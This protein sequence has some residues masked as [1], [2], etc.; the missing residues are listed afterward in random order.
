MTD[1]SFFRYKKTLNNSLTNIR[2]IQFLKLFWWAHKSWRDEFKFSYKQFTNII[3]EFV[4]IKPNIILNNEHNKSN[5]I[6]NPILI[7]TF[8]DYKYN[9]NIISMYKVTILKLLNLD[10]KIHDKTAI[11]TIVKTISITKFNNITIHLYL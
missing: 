5:T 10:N 11:L 2:T 1:Q 4:P 7:V 9:R 6:K 3:D 8:A